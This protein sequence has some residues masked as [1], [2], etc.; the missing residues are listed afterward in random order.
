MLKLVTIL[1]L[2]CLSMNG[3]SSYQIDRKTAGEIEFL[4]KKDGKGKVGLLD[5]LSQVISKD[6]AVKDFSHFMVDLCLDPSKYEFPIMTI[7]TEECRIELVERRV[8]DDL[9]FVVADSFSESPDAIVIEKFLNN[10]LNNYLD[11]MKAVIE[12]FSNW[13]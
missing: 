2:F 13:N 8:Q 11:K 7:N 1:A 12:V 4:L 5:T 9:A 3:F 10:Y 6:K